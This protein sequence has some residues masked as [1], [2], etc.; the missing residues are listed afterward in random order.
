MRITLELEP[1]D[2]ERFN[3]AFERVRKTTRCA[4]EVDVID[5]AKYALDHLGTSTAPAYVRKR[6]G[7]VQR[8]IAMLEDEA[9]A[10]ADPERT[11]VIRTLAYFSDPDD[12]IPDHIEVVGLLD[13]AIMLELLLRRLRRVRKAYA[14]FCAFRQ[15]LRVASNE[16][17]FHPRQHARELAELRASLHVRM[18]RQ[19]TRA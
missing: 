18:R 15:A 3:A 2:I 9:W 14:D 12:L 19:R 11:D 5:A 10:L 7:E 8:L 13:D 17:K 6:L 16:A 1:A 4:D